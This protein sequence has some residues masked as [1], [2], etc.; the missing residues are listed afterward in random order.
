MHPAH[1]LSLSP[2]SRSKLSFP[3]L[4]GAHSPLP[5]QVQQTLTP[6]P[7]SPPLMPPSGGICQVNGRWPRD[8]PSTHTCP[9]ARHPRPFPGDQGPLDW[10]ETQWGAGRI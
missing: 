3:C 7:S 1:V 5:P 8:G 4:P 10:D 6:E 9:L 2:I